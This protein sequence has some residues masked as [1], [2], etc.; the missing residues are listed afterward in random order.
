MHLRPQHVHQ[1]VHPRPG[2][3]RHV[4]VLAQALAHA[5]AADP[6][7]VVELL[8][9]DSLQ[10]RVRVHTSCPLATVTGERSEPPS[11]LECSFSRSRVC[12]S[13][14]G[15]DSGVFLQLVSSATPPS[16]VGR[17]PP[18]CLYRAAVERLKT[19]GGLLGSDGTSSG[20][21]SGGS[22]SFSS[23]PRPL[24]QT[25]VGRVGGGAAARGITL[26]PAQRARVHARGSCFQPG[27]VPSP[28]LP[29][30]F[31]DRLHEPPRE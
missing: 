8:A 6:Q 5:L 20:D 18:P 19:C 25:A 26:L 7:P 17:L 11:S 15:A 22:L 31:I 24:A 12:R 28:S 16:C 13:S 10:L 3:A 14:I 2:P 4:L 23:S 30:Q 29:V 9:G 27:I 21:G 1:A